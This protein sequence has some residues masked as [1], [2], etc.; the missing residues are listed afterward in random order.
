MSGS[1]CC[2]LPHDPLITCDEMA[3]AV[4]APT[5]DEAFRRSMVIV[6][7]IQGRPA[8]DVHEHRE[9]FRRQV[10]QMGEAHR[11]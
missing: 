4:A 10:R 7:R 1:M 5:E 8:D 3:W 2:G 11:E 9:G 6:E